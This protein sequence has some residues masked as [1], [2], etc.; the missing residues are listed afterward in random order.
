MLIG[1]YQSTLLPHL[2][3]NTIYKLDS[4][5]DNIQS[6]KHTIILIT[7][8]L[9]SL[10]SF[11]Q[12]VMNRGRHIPTSGTIALLSGDTSSYDVMYL[13]E[14]SLFVRYQ[15]VHNF[16]PLHKQEVD[17]FRYNGDNKIQYFNVNNNLRILRTRSEPGGFTVKNGNN[18]LVTGLSLFLIG[19][20]TSTLS[21]LIKDNDTKT[22]LNVTSGVSFTI[23]TVITLDGVS[24]RNKHYEWSKRKF[25]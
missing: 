16:T 12:S 14:D 5:T 8:L 6:M 4:S 9:F 15:N 23:G 3:L 25:R 21:A 7:F 20:V 19:G 1:T 17:W 2:Q 24:K 10:N 11:S 18:S 13:T 22:I